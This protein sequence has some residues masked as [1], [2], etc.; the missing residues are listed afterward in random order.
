MPFSLGKINEHHDEPEH[1][2][3]PIDLVDCVSGDIPAYSRL[4][5][6]QLQSLDQANVG[7]SDSYHRW[8][9]TGGYLRY[10][11]RVELSLHGSKAGPRD[12]CWFRSWV[13][14]WVFRQRYRL[15]Y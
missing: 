11:L 6:S 9:F 5:A 3:R 13:V 1:H 8:P 2:P 7:D 14:G 15:S 4:L 12:Q 10:L